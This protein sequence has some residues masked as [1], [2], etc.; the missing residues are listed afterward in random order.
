MT[1]SKNQTVENFSLV[2]GGPMFRLLCLLRASGPS[3]EHLPRR[4]LGSA[5]IA[6][7]PLLVLL[8]WRAKPSATTLRFRCCAT[9]KQAFASSWRYPSCSGRMS[10]VTSSLE[11]SWRSSVRSK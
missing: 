9:W 10:P 4:M 1:S 2:A 5:L 7:L 3:L 6:W 8:R 11:K